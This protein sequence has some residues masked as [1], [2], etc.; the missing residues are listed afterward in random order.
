MFARRPAR[1]GEPARTE[2]LESGQRLNPLNLCQVAPRHRDTRPVDIQGW[3][4]TRTCAPFA[5][6]RRRRGGDV[7]RRHNRLET[8]VNRRLTRLPLLLQKRLLLQG[9]L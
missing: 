3:G 6:R 9:L 1:H 2:D 7:P 5:C 8:R 4:V